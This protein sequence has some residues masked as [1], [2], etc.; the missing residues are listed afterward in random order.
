MGDNITKKKL[1]ILGTVI[2][3]L[4]CFPVHFIYGMF[5]NFITSIFF[6]VNESIWEHMKIFFTCIMISS[7]IQ[8]IIMF[9][10]NNDITNI[11]FSNFIGAI[12]SIPIFLLMFLPIYYFI[13]ENFIVTIFLMIITIIIVEIISYKLML[14]KDFK[15]ENKTILFVIFVYVIFGLLTYFP[16]Q[17]DL[18][19]DS[20]RCFS[21]NN[22]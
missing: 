17:Y 2:A 16:P 19:I 1:K 21:L 4:L 7:V 15:M 13:G 20:Q 6:P 5:P 14:K 9:K 10:T 3:I 22:S 12:L 8:K 11:C 18:F